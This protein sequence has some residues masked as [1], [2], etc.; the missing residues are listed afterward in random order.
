MTR[1]SRPKRPT[2]AGKHPDGRAAD[3]RREAL[4]RALARAEIGVRP[5]LATWLPALC[6]TVTAEAG[7]AFTIGRVGDSLAVTSVHSAGLDPE[8]ERL[9]DELLRSPACSAELEAASRAPLAE[10]DVPVRLLD[11]VSRQALAA[12]SFGRDLLRPLGLLS[13]EVVRVL[14]FEGDELLAWVGVARQSPFAVDE[15]RLIA[16]LVP[17]LRRRL[18]LERRVGGVWLPTSALERALDAAE[19]LQGEAPP[20]TAPEPALGA[21]S[22][23]AR[24][25]ARVERAQRAWRL[26]PRQAVVL[27]LLVAGKSNKEVAAAL[28]CAVRTVELHVT[29]L[30][31]AS[32]CDSRGELVARFY[33]AF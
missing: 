2:G 13:Q 25:R 23:E 14:V 9:A 15:R 26:S 17:P 33:S 22:G 11:L 8:G 21:A 12:S 3:A 18:A 24:L 16:A 6:S 7:L 5:A 27:E 1:G 10:R 29:G 4:D 20:G 28:G 31:E 19:R 32:R 30:L